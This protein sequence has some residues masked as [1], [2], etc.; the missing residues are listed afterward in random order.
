MHSF[1]RW[2]LSLSF[3]SLVTLLG[4]A[5]SHAITYNINVFEE[6]NTVTGTITTNGQLGSLSATDITQY[7]LVVNAGLGGSILIGTTPIFTGSPLTAGSTNLVFVPQ[8]GTAEFVDGGDIWLLINSL[9]F[10]PAGAMEF[11]EVHGFG[12]VN[13]RV[14]LSPDF[15]GHTNVQIGSADFT[16][17]AAV[18]GPTIGA[19]ASSF[20]LA[21]LMLGWFMRRRCAGL[22]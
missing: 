18:P 1:Q 15:Q 16:P 2:L 7:D 19:G 6:G 22:P 10:P 8:N 21:A 12:S 20:A 13:H 9:T 4:C 11:V 3:V 5:S 14:V 17:P